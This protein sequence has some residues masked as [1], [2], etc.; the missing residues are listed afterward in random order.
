M[1]LVIAALV[2]LFVSVPALAAEQ[3]DVVV[4]GGTSTGVAAAVQAA[5]SGRSVLLIEPTGHLGG[6]TSSGL[7]F[8]DYGRKETIGGI[9]LEFYQRIKKYYS[10]DK[11][12]TR[13]KRADYEFFN[14]DPDTMWRFEPHVAEKIMDQLAQEAGV[15]VV[16]KQRLDLKSGVKKTGAR[17]DSI[18]METGETYAGKV[19]I[20]A[21]YEGDLMAKA[22]VQYAV[23]REANSVYGE[24]FNGA[25]NNMGDSYNFYVP[26][27][28]YRIIDDPTSGLLPG[29]QGTPPKDG[30]GDHRIM[31]YNFRL[32]TTDDPDNMQPWSKPEN[33][34]EKDF[35]MLLRAYDKGY[36]GVPWHGAP[37]P[38]RKFDANSGGFVGSDWFGMNYEY[39]DGDYATREK[40]IAAHKYYMLGMAWTI[41][42]NP[43]VPEQAKSNLLKRGLTKDEFKETGGWGYTAYIREARRLISDY[44]MTE[45][46]ALWARKAPDSVGLANYGLDS[47]HVQ[48][49]VDANGHIRNE[50]NVL[51]P[52]SG[53]YPVSY[54][55]ITPKADQCENLLVPTCLASSHITYGSIRMEP[56]Y[57]I[58][59]QSAG[60]AAALAVEKGTTV[61]KV[62]YATLRT[63]LLAQKQILDF[64][65]KS[66]RADAVAPKDLKGI[67]LDDRDAKM[68]GYWGRAVSG[69]FVLPYT[70]VANGRRKMRS[71]HNGAVAMIPMTV[72]YETKLPEA[73]EYEV[74]VSYIPGPARAT[75][76][77]VIIDHAKGPSRKT[78]NQ[79]QPPD[80]DGMFVSVGTYTFDADKPAVVTISTDN[81]DGDVCADAIQFIKK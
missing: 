19:F 24:Q 73:G 43:R 26:V 74:R 59:G 46:D 28:A 49:H 63:R 47:H 35:E 37:M 57:M 22:G 8:T 70:L 27:S 66:T 25:Q 39:P 32:C 77:A 36:I 72:T 11:N 12:W 5:R 9:S 67:V 52:I 45:H 21:T 56:V 55:S 10:D 31:A 76:T 13:Q 69:K 33:Y 6:L 54:R 17:I 61:Q 23:G 1:K 42:S 2:A 4:Y 18:T 80:I 64:N 81:T 78:I 50:G 41:V 75:N 44:V 34:D 68:I 53:P 29:I 7:G 40:Y 51:V 3:Y 20:D 15:K 65:G 14:E 62:D 16:G 58:L 60:E 30:E 79:Q 48:R 71:W 38:N